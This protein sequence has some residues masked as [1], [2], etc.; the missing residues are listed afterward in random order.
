M[1]EDEINE[2]DNSNT[3]QIEQNTN[4]EKSSTNSSL[5]AKDCHKDELRKRKKRQAWKAR[6]TWP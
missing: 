2:I 4:P 5:T 1:T 3:Y 6:K